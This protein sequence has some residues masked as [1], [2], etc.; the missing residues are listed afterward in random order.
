MLLLEQPATGQL[1]QTYLNEHNFNVEKQTETIDFIDVDSKNDNE[2][3]VML[4]TSEIIQIKYTCITYR[5]SNVYDYGISIGSS[6]QTTPQPGDRFPYVIFS[7]CYYHLILF[8]NQQLTKV[9][10][11]VEFIK[12][13]YSKMI[14]IHDSNEEKIPLRFGGAILIRPD[15]YIVYRTNIFDIKHFQ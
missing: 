5:S 7:P 1:L 12:K 15:G 13:A 14:Q 9:N 6:H 8:E 11:F 4:S 2:V 3:Q 10:Q